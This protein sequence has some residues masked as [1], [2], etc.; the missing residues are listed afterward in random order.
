MRSATPATLG[1]FILLAVMRIEVA[2]G[3]AGAE[4][5]DPETPS[6]HNLPPD[7]T[8]VKMEV[9]PVDGGEGAPPATAAA[10][11]V[12][13]K[14]TAAPA[15]ADPSEDPNIGGVQP[16]ASVEKALSPIRP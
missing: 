2:C 5:G 9:V 10:A 6:R 8:E 13:P 14:G 1:F 15:T 4:G 16:D 12:A 11:P 7:R 3:G